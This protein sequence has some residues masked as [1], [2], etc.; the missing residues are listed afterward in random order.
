M[1]EWDY[2]NQKVPSPGKRITKRK[3]S[4]DPPRRVDTPRR[5]CGP[6]GAPCTASV[7]PWLRGRSWWLGLCALGTKEVSRGIESVPR[8]IAHYT[9]L[10]RP[11]AKGEAADPTASGGD[12]RCDCQVPGGRPDPVDL[13]VWSWAKQGYNWA[14]GFLRAQKELHIARW[15]AVQWDSRLAKGDSYSEI[16]NPER[17]R[18]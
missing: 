8:S 16:Q 10:S 13:K 1:P 2:K 4:S 11:A 6:L 15:G 5:L 7:R 18:W 17:V 12:Y 3:I 9:A 14:F